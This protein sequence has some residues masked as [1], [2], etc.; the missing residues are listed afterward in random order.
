MA[1]ASSALVAAIKAANKVLSATFASGDMKAVAALYT[2]DARLL[3]ANAPAHTGKAAIARFWT[4]AY[5]MGIQ[6]IALRTVEVES[7]GTTA[8]EYG[9]YTLKTA[10]GKALDNGKYVVVWKKQRGKWKLH[11]DI[12]NSNN[13]A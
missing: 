5:G 2:S 4:G 11:W 1:K 13:A 3:P 8:N 9:T 12:F 10:S 7:H 6:K